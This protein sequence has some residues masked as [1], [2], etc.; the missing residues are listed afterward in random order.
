[1]KGTLQ[2]SRVRG[3][4]PREEYNEILPWSLSSLGDRLNLNLGPVIGDPYLFKTLCFLL[5]VVEVIVIY[6]LSQ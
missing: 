3:I 1:M 4:P 6:S 2:L 5:P